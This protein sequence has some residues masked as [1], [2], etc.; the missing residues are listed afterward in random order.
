[1]YDT[2]FRGFQRLDDRGAGV[3]LGL[4]VSQGFVEAMGGLLVPSATPG[5]G[6]TMDIVLPTGDSGDDGDP[7]HD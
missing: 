1:M 3:G 7:G 4:A 2:I 5:G 6:L